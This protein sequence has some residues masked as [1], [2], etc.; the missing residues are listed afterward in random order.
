MNYELTKKLK[1]VRF[2]HNW[3]SFEDHDPELLVKD[4]NMYGKGYSPTLSELI[5]ACIH[6]GR[7]FNLAYKVNGVK[8]Q[9]GYRRTG[10]SIWRA[11]SYYDTAIS[12]TGVTPEEA[13][14]NLWLDLQVKEE[15]RV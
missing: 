6:N 7:N 12:Q 9:N 10:G 8:P 13:V 15:E 1:D 4:W 11:T 5:E 3:T 2:P 14:A